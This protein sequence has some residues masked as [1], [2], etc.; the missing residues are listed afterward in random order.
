MS[1]YKILLIPEGRCLSEGETTVYVILEQINNLT[2]LAMMYYKEYLFEQQQDPFSNH[3]KDI[4]KDLDV[5][6]QKSSLLRASLCKEAVFMS[7]KKAQ[8]GLRFYLDFNSP[9]DKK[10][11]L[12]EFE[13]IKE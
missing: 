13:F 11:H 6:L 2:K 3:A 5:V 4:I 10:Y 7:Y 1:K 8:Q 12:T 9:E